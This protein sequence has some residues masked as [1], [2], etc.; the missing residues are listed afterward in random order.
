[1]TL[2]HIALFSVIEG[3]VFFATQSD[4]LFNPYQEQFVSI[5]AGVSVANNIFLENKKAHGFVNAGGSLFLGDLVNN[6]FGPV[7]G[8]TYLSW[9]SLGQ[10][11]ILSLG[12]QLIVPLNLNFFLIGKLG[13]GYSEVRTCNGYCTESNNAVPAFGA[14][15]G[16]AVTKNWMGSFEF[17]GEYL[18]ESVSNGRGLTGA[19]TLGMTRF[20]HS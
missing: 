15:V 8:I 11:E 7:L 3:T 18:T 17:N 6:Y 9:G 20:W 19:L 10:A 4:A 1:M 5:N 16:F 13:L 14:G 2:R 12:G